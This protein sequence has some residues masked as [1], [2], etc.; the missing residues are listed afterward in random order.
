V[1]YFQH[2]DYHQSDEDFLIC[3]GSVPQNNAKKVFLWST[4]VETELVN[5]YGSV[6]KLIVSS[7]W[8][9]DRYASQI[10]PELVSKMVVI[11]PGVSQSF[12]PDEKDRWP[13]SVTFAGAPQKGGM[14]PLIEYSK[15]LK[16]KF[17]KSS[18]H[19]YGGAALL[20]WDNDQFRPVYDDLIKNK[21]L[22]HGQKGKKILSIHLKRNQIFLYPVSKDYQHAFGLMV[23]EAMVAGNIVIASDSGNLKN[24]VKDA[25][26]ILPGSP[27]DYKWQIEAVEKTIELFENPSLMSELSVKAH[28]YAKEYTWEKTVDKLT[29][30]FFMEVL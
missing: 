12:Y 23:L 1:K 15:R 17:P 27:F 18:I 5:K 28:T 24:L 14:K 22:Y 20:G 26:F 10:V 3:F 19:A 21:I 25:G 13:M 29:E 30:E 16:P 9:R 11:E 2:Y 8:H 7:D 6:D 4:K